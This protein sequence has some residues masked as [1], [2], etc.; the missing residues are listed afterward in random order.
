MHSFS[1]SYRPVRDS[2]VTSTSRRSSATGYLARP[3]VDSRLDAQL[4]P[5]EIRAHRTVQI[6]DEAWELWSPNSQRCPF[7]PGLIEDTLRV[8]VAD[9]RSER[10][11][12]GHLGRFDPCVSPQYSS[13]HP[14]WAPLVRRLPHSSLEC[15]EFADILDITDGSFRSRNFVRSRYVDELLRRNDSLDART[16]ELMV[17]SRNNPAVALE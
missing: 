17:I 5:F 3:C 7:L 11:S 10:R 9:G 4:P 8:E 12:D 13:G 16:T 14:A 15:P 2:R 1:A 6:G